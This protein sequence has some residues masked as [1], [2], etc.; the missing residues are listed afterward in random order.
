[1]YTSYYDLLNDVYQNGE[2][3]SP[4][5]VSTNRSFQTKELTNVQIKIDDF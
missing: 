2:L 4:S 3:I 5:D 1:M